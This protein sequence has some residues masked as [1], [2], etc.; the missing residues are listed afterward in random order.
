MKKQLLA[1]ALVLV[2][3]RPVTADVVYCTNCSSK[4][5][6]ALDRVTNLS[7]LSTLTKPVH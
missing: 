5:T 1:F 3:V 6:Q 4:F 2:A 7:Q